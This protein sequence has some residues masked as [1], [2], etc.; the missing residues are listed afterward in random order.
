VITFKKTIFIGLG[1]GLSLLIFAPVIQVTDSNK[2]NVTIIDPASGLSMYKPHSV[3]PLL[4]GCFENYAVINNYGFHGPTVKLEKKASVYRIVVVGSSYV[5]ARQVLVEDLFTTYLERSLND[6]IHNGF[7]YEV[8][9]LGVNGNG[10]FL[11]TLYYKY[12]GSPLKPDLVIDI[13]SGYELY[14]YFNPPS[15]N[16]EGEVVLEVTNKIED[17]VYVAFARAL[18]R[19][20]KLLVNLYS[21]FLV[22]REASVAFINRPL[23]FFPESKPT[24]QKDIV[25]EEESR[26]E[27]KEKLI[28]ALAQEAKE[29]GAQFLY[30]AYAGRE[31]PDTTIEEISRHMEKIAPK[32]NFKYAN[33]VPS[34]RAAEESTGKPAAFLPCD[35]HWS[36]DGHKFVADALFEYLSKTPSL[37]RK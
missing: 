9:P 3:V 7:R 33:L 1:L 15:F 29:D 19:N 14:R 35:G 37:L 30:A 26:W 5:E 25:G 6:K 12:Y 11:S 18:L 2:Y 8:I 17:N 32:W 24:Y 13:E 28:H 16:N 31:E 27:L 34:V 10:T 23:F 22:F 36:K 4:T 21:R 20:S